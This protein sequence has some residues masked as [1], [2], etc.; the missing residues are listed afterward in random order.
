MKDNFFLIAI[1]CLISNITCSMGSIKLDAKSEA[2]LLKYAL[3]QALKDGYWPVGADVTLESF[4]CVN[5]A[6]NE[7]GKELEYEAR[8]CARY[9]EMGL[10]NGRIGMLNMRRDRSAYISAATL[11]KNGIKVPE[12]K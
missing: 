4:R 2:N 3:V 9:L 7:D 10:Y 12:Q 8:F 11:E 5:E 6:G 1:F